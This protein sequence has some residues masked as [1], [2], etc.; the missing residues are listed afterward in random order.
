MISER[1]ATER[2]DQRAFFYQT[3]LRL[4]HLLNET[5]P[6]RACINCSKFPNTGTPGGPG[7]IAH[8]FVPGADFK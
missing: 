3:G 6:R 4:A 7:G 2:L 8:L 5:A 1:L